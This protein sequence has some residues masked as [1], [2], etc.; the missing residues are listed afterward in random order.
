MLVSQS[1]LFSNR[2]RSCGKRGV[3]SLT[4][5]AVG[6]AS[7]ET[8]ARRCWQEL[9]GESRPDRGAG[10][11]SWC[12]RAPVAQALIKLVE[13]DYSCHTLPRPQIRRTNAQGRTLRY[14]GSL[15]PPII[16]FI[17]TAYFDRAFASQRS[18]KSRWLHI[19]P[20]LI[21]ALTVRHTYRPVGNDDTSHY[22][23]ST[24]L[25]PITLAHM[26]RSARCV[27][28]IQSL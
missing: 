25:G 9:A 14:S 18:G 27:T 2:V 11:R 17:F 6:S 15:Q 21:V 3:C 1:I 4:P 19:H 24:A 28:L 22:P 13:H 26:D 23:P 8:G 16:M 20:H 7:L 10:Q 12:Q 5:I